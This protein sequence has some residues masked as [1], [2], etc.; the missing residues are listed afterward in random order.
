MS[1]QATASMTAG[2]ASPC[3]GFESVD[4]C[5]SGGAGFW[6]RVTPGV[7]NNYNNCAWSFASK[8]VSSNATVA[9]FCSLLTDCAIPG[10]DEYDELQHH[11]LLPNVNTS[12][13]WLVS[14]QHPCLHLTKP[15][16]VISWLIFLVVLIPL[17]P[18]ALHSLP[19]LC[20]PRMLHTSWLHTS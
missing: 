14:A 10:F 12:S 19:V 1:V 16:F 5:V 7:S 4:G 15:R 18:V 8:V 6:T 11:A 20:G 13:P 3:D 9:S 2:S 17:V